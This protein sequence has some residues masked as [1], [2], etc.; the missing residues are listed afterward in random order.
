MRSLIQQSHVTASE[1]Y[2]LSYQLSVSWYICLVRRKKATGRTPFC[3]LF[4]LP[5]LVIEVVER[6]FVFRKVAEVT[7]RKI[8]HP[9]LIPENDRG[10]S[11][12]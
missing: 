7:F 10:S 8:P 5:H 1:V 4:L 12:K 2:Q 11:A 6:G 9:Q 3:I